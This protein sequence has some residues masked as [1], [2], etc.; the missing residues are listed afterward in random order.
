MCDI[1]K[2]AKVRA[3]GIAN[4]STRHIYELENAR[5]DMMPHVLQI[6]YHPFRT[7]SETREACSQRKIQIEAYSANCLMLPFVRE[8]D[9]LKNIAK[10]HNKTIT[11]IIMRWHVQQGTV[12]IF[13][14]TNH[15][16]IVDNIDVFDFELSPEEMA[17][18]FNLD[19]D[20]KFHPESLNC[21]GY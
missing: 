15:E 1:Y 3:I 6:E 5:V 16:H 7:I 17:A 2:S 14:S 4:C 12:P 19:Q 9:V 18:I 21:P 8:N 20:Y 10:E 11:Q 13:S